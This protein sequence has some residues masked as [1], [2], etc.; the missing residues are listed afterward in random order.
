[1][2]FG[3]RFVFLL[4]FFLHNIFFEN[5]QHHQSS[6]ALPL[7]NFHHRYMA[8]SFYFLVCEIYLEL[9][10][11]GHAGVTLNTRTPEEELW[12]L[13]TAL[14]ECDRL[15]G[16]GR[17]KHILIPNLTSLTMSSNGYDSWGRRVGLRLMVFSDDL[18]PLCLT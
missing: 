7:H 4:K 9:T 3:T 8:Q 5:Y 11:V 6:L 17:R 13:M 1:M 10:P 18:L 16:R 12:P 2:K 14:A 15:T